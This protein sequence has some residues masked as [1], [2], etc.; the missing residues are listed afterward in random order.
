[1]TDRDKVIKFLNEMGIGY[2]LDYSSD[3]IWL[4]DHHNKVS[5][6]TE[7]SSIALTFCSKYKSFKE[8]VIEHN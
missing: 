4:E 2:D 3:T 6:L 8:I 7:Y 1:M 5:G